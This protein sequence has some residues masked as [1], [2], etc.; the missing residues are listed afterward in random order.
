MKPAYKR[1]IEAKNA[2]L[3]AREQ[4]HKER[5]KEDGS[6]M[7]RKIIYSLIQKGKS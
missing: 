2:Y 4:L 3:E 1:Y 5:P 6:P 7:D